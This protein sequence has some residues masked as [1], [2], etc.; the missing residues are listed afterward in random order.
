MYYI[1]LEYFV[2]YII[3][4]KV[5]IFFKLTFIIKFV[6]RDKNKKR[7]NNE[8]LFTIRSRKFILWQN[9]NYIVDSYLLIIILKKFK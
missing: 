9:C 4:F 5:N 3:L 7:Q 6:Q 2:E 8:M 1:V